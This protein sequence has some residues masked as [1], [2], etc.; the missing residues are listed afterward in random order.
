MRLSVLLLFAMAAWADTVRQVR[1]SSRSRSASPAAYAALRHTEA[2]GRVLSQ[3]GSFWW[4]K[5]DSEREWLT[6]EFKSRRK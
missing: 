3:S 1:E 2:I 4:G 6:A 5:S